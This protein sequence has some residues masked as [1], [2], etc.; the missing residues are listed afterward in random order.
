MQEAVGQ[1]V[2]G[3]IKGR[4][5]EKLPTRQFI[6]PCRPPSSKEEKE[7]LTDSCTQIFIAVFKCKTNL[8]LD[9]NRNVK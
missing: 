4:A 7:I 1:E 2:V 3:E 6:H 8:Q 9:E 5:A